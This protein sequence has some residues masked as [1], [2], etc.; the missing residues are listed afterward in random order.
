M[1]KLFSNGK[2]IV[3]Y[4]SAFSILAVS[5]LSVFTGITVTANTETC[6]GTIIEKWD[7][8]SD[9]VSG[10]WYDAWDSGSVPIIYYYTKEG[11]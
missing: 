5:L 3:A 10:D 2:A 8:V 7:K 11:E 6:G 9:G 1:K 4:I